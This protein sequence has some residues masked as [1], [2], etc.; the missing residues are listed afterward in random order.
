MVDIYNGVNTMSVRLDRRVE[1]RGMRGTAVWRSSECSVAMATGQ[2]NIALWTC[3][4]SEL[5]FELVVFCEEER[6]V[7][8]F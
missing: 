8:E 2:V 4:A 6:G 5:I 7:R 3:S 1:T